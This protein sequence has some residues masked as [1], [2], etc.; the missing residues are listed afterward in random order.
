MSKKKVVLKMTFDDLLAIRFAV[1]C[2]KENLSLNDDGYWRD[3][4]ENFRVSMDDETHDDL[5]S[6]SH[7]LNHYDFIKE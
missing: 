1:R 7:A 3:N 2:V 4:Y 5:V 6:G